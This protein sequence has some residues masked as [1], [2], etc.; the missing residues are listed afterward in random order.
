MF[1][2]YFRLFFLVF[3]IV[4]L[5]A[6]SGAVGCAG[7]ADDDT[8]ATTFPETCAEVQEQ[9]VD[10]TGEL[11]ADGTYTLYVD[12]D[13]RMPWEAFCYNMTEIEPLEYLTVTDTDNYSQISNGTVIVETK[14]SQLR[15]DPIRLE[16]DPLDDTF[17]TTTDFEEFTPTFP[18]ETM[19]SI[20]AGWAEFQTPS[21]YNPSPIDAEA[22]ASLADTPFVFSEDILADDLMTFFCQ[23]DSVADQEMFTDGT[24]VTV[25]ED[26][27]TAF[28]LTAINTNSEGLNS[29][30][31]RE[32]ADCEN[33]GTGATDFS[34]AAW[35][36]TYVGL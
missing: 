3:G 2:F 18:V 24:D 21:E 23:V 8:T 33:L 22:K 30:S 34:T 11:P 7:K 16:I 15:I 1:L 12:G 35:P 29:I 20:P 26:D 5:T 25:M 19:E 27:L 32:V 36:L 28:T 9:A 31:T 14:Y 13:E 4:F 17:A 10:E 6:F